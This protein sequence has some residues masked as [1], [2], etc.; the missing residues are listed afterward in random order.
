MSSPPPHHHR[1]VFVTVL[2]CC[3]P[4]FPLP[5]LSGDAGSTAVRAAVSGA[6]SGDAAKTE[7]CVVAVR[8]SVYANMY[9][10][11]GHALTEDQ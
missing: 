4:L 8:K 11:L 9:K 3:L 7:A 1:Q 2:C 6:V 5:P 10:L